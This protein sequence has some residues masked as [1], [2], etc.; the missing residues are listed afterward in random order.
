MTK[1][2]Q[3][4]KLISLLLF[5]LTLLFY[6]G[7]LYS[8]EDI[9][10]KEEE[11]KA[12]IKQDSKLNNE[13]SIALENTSGEKI[14]ISEEK[15][16]DFN[17]NLIGIFDP[18]KNNFS[19]E[20]WTQSDGLD[21]KKMLNKIEKI[22]LSNF[23]EDLLSQVL[24]T[25]A[26]PPTK[27]LNIEK[28]LKIKI[29]WLIKNK[30]LKDLELLLKKNPRL[31]KDPRPIKIL[32]DEYLS[33]SDIDSA[34]TKTEFLSKDI[35]ND[36]IDKF[37]VYCLIKD[38]R[39]EEAQLLFDL[40]LERGFKD[41]FFENKFY[42]LVGITETSNQKVLDNNLLNFYLSYITS[43]D[44]KYQ[45][46]DKTD[47]YILK[48]MS[49]A[50]LINTKD[51][52]NEE[53]ILTYEKA[54]SEDSFES[55]SVFKI[56]LQMPFTFNQLVN[57][58]EI[59]NNLPSYKARALIYQSILLTVDP[60]K[61]IYLSFLLKDLFKKD[62]IYPVYE[63]ELSSI[64]KQ[65][66]PDEI[67]EQYKEIVNEN[68]D[69]NFTNIKKVKF[70]NNILHKSK[71]VRHFLENYDKT[72]RTE[73]DLKTV[74]KKVKK[75]K[76]Y[77]ISI[78][79]IIVL[80]SLVSDGVKI[81]NSLNYTSLSSEFIAPK[82]LEDLVEQEQVGLVLLKIIEIIGEDKVEDLDPETLYFLTK[83]L[84]QLN[85]KKIRNSILSK[86]LNVKV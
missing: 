13:S 25:N 53:I 63:E 54:A 15:I 45:P 22:K 66:D 86:A 34:C 8:A 48:F 58:T 11:K 60:E 16:E 59:Y 49:S 67:P 40:M 23:S 82:G 65:I 52:E 14:L 26:Y 69:P 38:E 19:L 27:N 6:T 30:R 21:I 51:L 37:T 28:F 71:I 84:N 44:F 73:K 55:D 75:N 24:F 1:L 31:I 42:Y 43:N 78:M 76:K 2:L 81:P 62:K 29:D 10:K 39:K 56:Y 80:E 79:D 20:M 61:K 12:E 50:N 83:I 47:Q 64:L 68:I 41:K 32:V 77:F 57:S 35:K 72:T 74:Y 85:L 9:W 70:N 36:Y 46:T 7:N 4:N 3:L 33:S 18:E 5:F 17:Q